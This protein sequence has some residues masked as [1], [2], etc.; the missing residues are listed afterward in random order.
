MWWFPLKSGTCVA[1]ILLSR[2]T[3]AQPEVDYSQF[4]NPLIG[5]SGPFEGQACEHRVVW[6]R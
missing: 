1:A 4:V 3:L 2:H 6:S 5:G